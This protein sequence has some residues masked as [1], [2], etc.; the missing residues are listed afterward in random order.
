MT[1]DLTLIQWLSIAF[2]LL[3]IVVLWVNNRYFSARKPVSQVLL[4]GT[5]FLALYAGESSS[6]YAIALSIILFT[7]YTV[8]LC[9]YYVAALNYSRKHERLPSCKRP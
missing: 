9:Q 2:I 6:P 8:T 5:L 7:V 3:P 4:G 1:N